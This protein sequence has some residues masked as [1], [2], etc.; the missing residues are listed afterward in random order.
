VGSSV[1]KITVRTSIRELTGALLLV[2]IGGYGDAASFLLVGCFTGH[3]TGNSVLAG[4]ALAT[5]GRA[6]EPILAVVC[7]LCATASAQRLRSSPD[8]PFGSRGFHYVLGAEITLVFVSPFLLMAQHRY[9]FIACMSL[10]LG[11][12]NGAISRADGISLHTTY[13]T[14]T[15]TRLLS[16]LTQPSSAK[17]SMNQSEM[18]FIPLVWCAFIVGA[19]CGGLTISRAGPKGVWG[20][21]LLLAAVLALSSLVPEAHEPR[22]GNPG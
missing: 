9:A 6:W 14:G 15:L 1:E 4:I 18:R 12:Q 3:T 13:L 16:L 20:M 7:F 2:A 8:Q 22:A 19:L 5:G 10:A 11:L 21:P 17:A